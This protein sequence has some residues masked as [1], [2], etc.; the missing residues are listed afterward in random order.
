MTASIS[1]RLWIRSWADPYFDQNCIVIQRR[2]TRACL[3]VDPGLQFQVVADVI[4]HEDLKVEFILLTHGHVDHVF[5]VP[6][7]RDLTGAPTYMHPLDQPQLARNP[8]TIRQ[9]GLDPGQFGTPVID[10]DLVEG[11]PVG[12]QDLAFEVIHTPG[13]TPGSVCF[14]LGDRCLGGD[15]LFRRGVGRSDLFGGDQGALFDSIRDKLF[16]LAPE[17][18]VYPGHGPVTTI[19][20]ETRENPFVSSRR[21]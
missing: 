21:T 4:E 12:W 2:D 8:T 15:T 3:V 16:R 20:E 9:F 14:L 5:G 11:R 10:H 7:I 17:T 1:D 13:H 6:A 19:G 18:V